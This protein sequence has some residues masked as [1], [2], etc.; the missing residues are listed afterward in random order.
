MPG[1]LVY[2]PYRQSPA[3]EFNVLMRASGP[4]DSAVAAL[5]AEVRNIDPDLPLLSVMTVDDYLRSEMWAARVFGAVFGAFAVMALLMSSIG[6]YGVTA[7]G[8]TQRT[9]EIG[10]RMALGATPLNVVWLVLRQ[11]LLIVLGIGLRLLGALGVNFSPF[12]FAGDRPTGGIAS[13][14]ILPALSPP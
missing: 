13:I 11:G 5:R 10:V 3:A 1:P 2:I 8:I 9:Q 7:Y 6:L 14:S 12:C 4:R